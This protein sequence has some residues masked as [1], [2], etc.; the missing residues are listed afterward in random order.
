MEPDPLLP[1]QVSV[2]DNSRAQAHADDHKVPQV[3]LYNQRPTEPT[4]IK[5]DP[6]PCVVL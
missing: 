1:N 6:C 5:E 3:P 2:Y 4:V